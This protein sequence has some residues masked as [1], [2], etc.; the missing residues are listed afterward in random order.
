[1]SEPTAEAP[2]ETCRGEGE[3]EEDKFHPTR[4]HYTC[5]VPCPSCAL[6]ME[7]QGDNE[8][9]AFHDAGWRDEP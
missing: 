4:G 6:G 3:I 9:A 2:C 1:M 5:L 8:N 7:R